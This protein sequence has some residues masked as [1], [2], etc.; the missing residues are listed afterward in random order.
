M[1]VLVIEDDADIS[2]MLTYYF[3]A[4]GHEVMNAHDGLD[5]L[6][7]FK[8]QNPD[9]ILLD[10]MLPKLD[11]WAVLEAVRAQSKV[12]VILL[13]ALG[14]TEDVVK[15]LSLG[16]DDYLRKPFEIRELEARIISIARRLE[17]PPPDL[18]KCGNITINDRSKTV[19][20][21]NKEVSLS[22]KEYD[23]LKLLASDPG[24]VFTNAE[25]VDHIWEGHDRATSIDV[26]QCIYHLRNRIEHEPQSPQLI[27]NVKGFGYKLVT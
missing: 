24:R 2:N 18:I 1:K 21:D 15:G 4:K 20:I 27:Q 12:P 10:I 16:A 14:D 25:I 26:K 17:Q 13:T 5:A 23:L 3:D 7:Q 9:L 19:T 11:G 6:R 8:D 22:P